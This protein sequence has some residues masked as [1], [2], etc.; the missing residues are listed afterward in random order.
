MGDE[1][2]PKNTDHESFLDR[3]YRLLL[4]RRFALLTSIPFKVSSLQQGEV[5]WQVVLHCPLFL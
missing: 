1:I 4:T 2:R 5:S 3:A